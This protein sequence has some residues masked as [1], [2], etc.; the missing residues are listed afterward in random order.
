MYTKKS[1]EKITH[2][3]EK[4]LAQVTALLQAGT[5][6]RCPACGTLKPQTCFDC[7]HS[8]CGTTPCV[9]WEKRRAI[10]VDDVLPCFE[11]R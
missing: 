2:L 11:S 9:C 6:S 10:K 7:R 1:L 8:W 3:L 5:P 4:T